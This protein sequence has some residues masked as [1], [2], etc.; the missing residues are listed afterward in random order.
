MARR[1]MFSPRRNH[2]TLPLVIT[3]GCLILLTLVTLRAEGRHWWCACGQPFLWEGNIWCEH[4]SQHFFD[5]YTFSHILHGVI[6]CGI[7][8]WIPGFRRHVGWMLCAAIGLEGLWEIAENSSFVINRYRETTIALGYEGDSIL[9][10]LSDILCCASGFLLAHKIGWKASVAFF[11]IVEL[12]LL[13][14]IR[15]NLTLNVLMLLCPIEG[16][17]TWQMAGQTL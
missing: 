9:N 1:N 10:S 6:F 7:F 17:K 2:P 11:V 4:T 3:A 8:Y 12:V 16:I 5:P 13:W 14:S 15:D